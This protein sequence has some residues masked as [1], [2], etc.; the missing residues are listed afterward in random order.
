MLRTA[1]QR[2]IVDQWQAINREYLGVTSGCKS[3]D[4]KAISSVVISGLVLTCMQYLVLRGAL[5]DAVSN[6]LPEL[7]AVLWSQSAGDWL[8]QYRPLLRNITWSLGCTFMYL[9]VPALVVTLLYKEKLSD[10]G[11]SPKGYFKHLWIYGL[12]FI[13]VGIAVAAV[14][15][16]PGFQQNYPFYKSAFGLADLIVWELFYAMQ[17]FALEFFFRGFMLK[18]LTEKLGANAILF[19]VVPYCMI[20][21]Q[22]PMLETMGAIIAGLILGIL[23]LRTRSI[24]GGATIHVA[25]AVSMDVAV[26]LQKGAFH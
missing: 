9:V 7:V 12:L 26:L 10:W 15:F 11:L 18:G 3:G 21:F 2:F 23:A 1:Y 13:P 22:K 16:T 24:W 5:Q 6:Q 4:Y 20:H 8:A 19:M 25:V 17:F 14:S